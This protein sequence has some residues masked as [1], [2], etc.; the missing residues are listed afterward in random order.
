MLSRTIRSW[1]I[2]EGY[3]VIKLTTMRQYGTAGWPDLL[4]LDKAPRMPLFVE[5]KTATGKATP[6]QERR[7][8]QLRERGYPVFIVRSLQE[9][10]IVIA[11]WMEYRAP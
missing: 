3:E 7:H 8:E 1:L 11:A 10:K 9:T 6:L 4:V 5:I 2:C